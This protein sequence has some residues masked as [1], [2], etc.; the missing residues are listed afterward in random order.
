M[1]GRGKVQNE[2]KAQP[3]KNRHAVKTRNKQVKDRSTKIT[4]ETH[5]G[6]F[7][8]LKSLGL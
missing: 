1:W 4:V 3:V 5:K 6:A 8:L 7:K 2:A